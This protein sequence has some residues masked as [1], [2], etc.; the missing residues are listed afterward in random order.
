MGNG[1]LTGG[2][3]TANGWL[4]AAGFGQGVLTGFVGPLDNTFSAFRKTN[5]FF[6]P[7]SGGAQGSLLVALKGV[8]G[9]QRC[10]PRGNGFFFRDRGGGS[11]CLPRGTLFFL[12]RNI[13]VTQRGPQFI[14]SQNTRFSRLQPPKLTSV[15]HFA[16]PK[17]DEMPD[18]VPLEA[19]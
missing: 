13:R 15:R 5:Y 6:S 7:V 2:E 3:W 19:H 9:P 1:W 17:I 14:S 12:P 4:A 10:H 8:W 16:T 11:G 18:R